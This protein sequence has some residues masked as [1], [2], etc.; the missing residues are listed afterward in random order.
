MRQNEIINIVQSKAYGE[1]NML[2]KNSNKV[3]M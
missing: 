1:K 2:R 3:E